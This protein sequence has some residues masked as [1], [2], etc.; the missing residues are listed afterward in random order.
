MESAAEHC[1]A[2]FNKLTKTSE[3][4]A[5][6]LPESMQHDGVHRQDVLKA[7][8]TMYKALCVKEIAKVDSASTPQRAII[9]SALKAFQK[10]AGECVLRGV[11]E[12]MHVDIQDFVSRTI[13][14]RK[15]R[16]TR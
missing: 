3:A 11:W 5:V 7:F 16:R 15:R 12:K 9:I 8:A 14:S 2:L 6:Q 13:D 10:K 4:Y 1:G